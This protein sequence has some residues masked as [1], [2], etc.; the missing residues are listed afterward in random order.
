MGGGRRPA[1]RGVRILCLGLAVLL[2][3]AL[4]SIVLGRHGSPDAGSTGTVTS[5]SDSSR[6]STDADRSESSAY[7][8][9]E[10]SGIPTPGDWSRQEGYRLVVED[11]RARLPQT[12]SESSVDPLE[13]GY[14]VIDTALATLDA[15]LD[16]TADDQTWAE[17]VLDSL[18]VDGGGREHPVSDAPRWWW[19][20][21]RFTPATLCSAPDD[22][23][24]QGQY[25]GGCTD[26]DAWD[27]DGGKAI[28]EAGMF[29]TTSTDFP[30]ADGLA[31][32]STTNPQDTVSR[33]YG[34]VS[35]PMDDGIWH[36]TV[37]CPATLDGPAVD[38]NGSELASFDGVDEAWTVHGLTGFGTVDRPC[39]TVEV[40]VGGQKPFWWF[41]DE[42]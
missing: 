1:S 15:L 7:P 11:G 33:A 27:D 34:V 9:L 28:A 41:G 38:R 3:C 13:G 12:E 26:D 36:V 29:D 20:E 17:H 8:G 16:P 14:G 39:V 31:L 32:D 19:A 18:G 2:V 40:T 24:V 35:V 5:G 21:R 25:R 42:S 4:G 6:R 30:V 37:Y 23:Y 22:P 10:A